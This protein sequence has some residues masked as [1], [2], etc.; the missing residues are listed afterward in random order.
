MGIFTADNIYRLIEQCSR[1]FSPD[2]WAQEYDKWARVGT[3]DERWGIANRSTYQVVDWA[4]QRLAFLDTKYN[5]S[6]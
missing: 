2:L 5:Y 6:A 1:M 3:P 4:E